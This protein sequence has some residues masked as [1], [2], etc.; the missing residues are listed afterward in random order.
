MFGVGRCKSLRRKGRISCQSR[1]HRLRPLRR[2]RRAPVNP[3]R[4]LEHSPGVGTA[5]RHSPPFRLALQVER[6]RSYRRQ[7]LHGPR[8]RRV[9][10]PSITTVYRPMFT[11][12]FKAS[13]IRRSD[14]S[15]GQSPCTFGRID[16]SQLHERTEWPSRRPGP[17]WRRSHG[18]RR[19][20]ARSPGT[21]VRY[22]ERAEDRVILWPGPVDASRT[23]W[24]LPN[25][26]QI[27][28]CRDA[29]PAGPGP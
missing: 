3:L 2:C 28:P 16:R 22:R 13:A 5:P 24:D 7:G 20:L 11:L 12:R 27:S 29:T 21:V 4:R 6:D 23:A 9:I 8:R 10:I 19:R 25:V 15:V 26:S 1:H 18:S 17:S 14:R